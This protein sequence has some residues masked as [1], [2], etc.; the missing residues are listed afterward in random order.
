MTRCHL[1][2]KNI[3]YVHSHNVTFDVG[4]KATTVLFHT[5]TFGHTRVRCAMSCSLTSNSSMARE[6]WRDK[7]IIATCISDD[8]LDMQIS[9][10][11][12]LSFV[13]ILF[14]KHP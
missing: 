14:S 10:K 4:W 13:E 5:F 8:R 11:L 6:I 7:V 2:L 1:P 9:I 3:E 12:E